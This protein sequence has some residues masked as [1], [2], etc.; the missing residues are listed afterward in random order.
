[1]SFQKRSAGKLSVGCHVPA[2]WG[3]NPSLQPLGALDQRLIA[4]VLGILTGD[5]AAASHIIAACSF[6]DGR[7][8]PAKLATKSTRFWMKWSRKPRSTAPPPHQAGHGGASAV[9]DLNDL[10][11]ASKEGKVRA[12]LRDA[13]TAG[14]RAAREGRK[15]W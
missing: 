13:A 1:M 5:A 4:P 7:R 2:P 12:L 8:T 9:V 11:E 15:R 3:Q 6:G 10:L 14:A